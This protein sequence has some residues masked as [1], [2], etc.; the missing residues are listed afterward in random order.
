M[1]VRY[2]LSTIPLISH[3]LQYTEYI[4]ISVDQLIST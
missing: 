3:I 4:I 1:H 2:G